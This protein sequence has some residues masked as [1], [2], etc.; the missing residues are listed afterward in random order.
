MLLASCSYL[1]SRKYNC[2]LV[3]DIEG[4]TSKK[5][6][7]VLLNIETDDVE[8][9]YL[10]GMGVAKCITT[11]NSPSRC[12]ID[13][14]GNV[15]RLYNYGDDLQGIE[16]EVQG[17]VP[18]VVFP[19]GFSDMRTVMSIVEK[20]PNARVTGGNL[21]EIPGIRIGRYDEGKEKM[22]AVFNGVYDAFKEVELA[23][24][25]IRRIVS[26][27]KSTSSSRRSSS[28]GSDKKKVTAKSKKSKTFSKFFGSEGDAF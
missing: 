2:K 11:T 12:P 4:S 18:L 24:I 3:L 9:I 10:G 17:V 26:K 13:F 28:S 6:E 16:N 8:E 19:D 27:A 20:Y 22:P 25:S 15:F 5:Q 14:H 1:E 23:D 21:L 7:E